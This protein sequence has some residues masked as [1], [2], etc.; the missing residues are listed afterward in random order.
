[1]VG[2]RKP[3]EERREEL[4]KAAREVALSEGLENVTGR[5]VAA[6][7]GLSSGLVFFHFT[8]RAGLLEAVLDALLEDLFGSMQV[9]VGDGAPLERFLGFVEQRMTRLRRERRQLELFIDFWVLGVRQPSIRKR[10]RDGLEQY[11]AQ[12]RPMAEEVAGT[13]AGMTGEGLSQ[14]AVSFILGAALQ[15]A[16]DSQRIDTDVHVEAVRALFEAQRPTRKA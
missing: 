3:P 5:K 7:A 6:R 16:M 11:R 9:P 8:D 2:L 13:R 4:V 1:M 15:L 12:L 14:I 10:M